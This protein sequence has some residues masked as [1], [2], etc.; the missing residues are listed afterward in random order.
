MVATKNLQ[1]KAVPLS[2]RF[3][4]EKQIRADIINAGNSEDDRNKKM[5]DSYLEIGI[6]SPSVDH[7]CFLFAEPRTMLG[8]YQ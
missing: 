4:R 2:P 5:Y 1:F 8:T 7:C 6:L 3:A